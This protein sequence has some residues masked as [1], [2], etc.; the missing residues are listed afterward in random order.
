MKVISVKSVASAQLM[1]TVCDHSRAASRR[2]TQYT[3][4]IHKM[5]NLQ[6]HM[7]AVKLSE[8]VQLPKG[9]TRDIYV[10][11]LVDCFRRC[12]GETVRI[13]RKI[14]KSFVTEARTAIDNIVT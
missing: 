11:Q 6:K 12:D 13:R 8:N 7:A 3:Y 5:R 2:I 10:R 14:P 9:T 1:N 4:L